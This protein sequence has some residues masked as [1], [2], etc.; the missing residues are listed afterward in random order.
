MNRRW[1]GGVLA[2]ALILIVVAGL[3]LAQ[4]RQ[5]NR[6]VDRFIAGNS[7]LGIEMEEVTADNM[8]TYKLGAERGVIVRNVQKGSPAAD[9]EIH[10]KDVITDYDGMPVISTTQLSRLVQETPAGRKVALG[11][12]REGKKVSLTAKIAKRD[13]PVLLRS[14]GWQSG[15]MERGFQFGPDGPNFSFQIP[16]GKGPFAF[17]LPFGRGEAGEARP[18]LGVMLQP[19]TEQMAEFLGVAGKRG[20]LVTSVN[21]GSPAAAAK[22]RAGDVVVRAGDRAVE[23]P[24]DLARA[25]ERA[26]GEKLDLKVVRDKREITITVELPKESR[27][28]RGFRL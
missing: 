11:V 4:G 2:A 22:L 9:A 24:Q 28:S 6:I 10:E 21:E 7:Y 3:A 5:G 15:P 8:A 20:A 14:E 1:L 19:L 17:S 18:L 12:S 23:D 16:N 25:V 13:G 26:A 27:S